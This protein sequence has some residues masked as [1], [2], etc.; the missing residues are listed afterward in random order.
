[1]IMREGGEFRSLAGGGKKFLYSS[2]TRNNGA[3]END[4]F[5]FP[6]SKSSSSQVTPRAGMPPLDLDN[7]WSIRNMALGSASKSV[8]SEPSTL[9]ASGNPGGLSTSSV[10]YSRHGGMRGKPGN[11]QRD[12]ISSQQ[13]PSAPSSQWSSS[14]HSMTAARRQPQAFHPASQGGDTQNKLQTDSS[15]KDINDF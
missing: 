13:G 5:S 9:K 8:R 10:Y 11:D 15:S 4:P 7:V 3:P 6:V 1:M 14:S 2:P 12:G